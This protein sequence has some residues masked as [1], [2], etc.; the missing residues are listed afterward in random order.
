MKR[1]YFSLAIAIIFLFPDFSFASAERPDP[2]YN[3]ILVRRVIDGDTVEL[4]SRERVRLIGIDTP[5][6]HYSQKLLR[7]SRKSK[8]DIEAIKA[9]G[10][11]AYQF[12]RG[13]LEGKRVD[14][15]LDVEK[16]DRYG[17]LLAYVYLKD[18]TFVNARIVEEGYASLLTIPPNIKHADLFLR[19]YRKARAENRGLWSEAGD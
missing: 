2:G 13:L 9:M 1:F 10:R 18:G 17:R 16:R 8:K 4:E 11:R 19:L 3:D 12:T 6:M 7:D 14:L 5:E 15:E